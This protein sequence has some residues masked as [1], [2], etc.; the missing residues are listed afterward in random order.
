LGVPQT[1]E[2][3]DYEVIFRETNIMLGS[4]QYGLV[5]GL[6]THERTFHYNDE[7]GI[8]DIAEY[9]DIPNLVKT[10]HVGFLLNPLIYPFKIGINNNALVG[11]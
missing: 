3:G 6:S 4:G 2:P 7:A 10:S 11:A 8:L 9:S 1:I 5:V